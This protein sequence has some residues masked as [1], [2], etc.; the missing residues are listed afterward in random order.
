[1][2]AIHDFFVFVL[3]TYRHHVSKEYHPNCVEFVGK[4]NRLQ[5]IL[6]PNWS[7]VRS[8]NTKGS[9]NVRKLY[10]MYSKSKANTPVNVFVAWLDRHVPLSIKILSSSPRRLSKLLF[11]FFFN[12][13]SILNM[14]QLKSP[15][16]ARGLIFAFLLYTLFVYIPF[17]FILLK[18]LTFTRPYLSHKIITHRDYFIPGPTP[19]FK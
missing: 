6:I 19:F 3:L 7:L 15:L 17:C 9:Q 5:N 1:M 11:S 4:K 14:L 13:F 10:T 12:C 2:S 16:T 8:T 18:S